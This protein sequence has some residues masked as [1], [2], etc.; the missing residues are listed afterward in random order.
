M[1]L[2]DGSLQ[3]VTL[4]RGYAWMYTGTIESL[5]KAAKF[6]R[7]IESSAGQKISAVEEIAYTNGWIDR[8]KLHP[9]LS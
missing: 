7:T 6:V 8:D 4:G 9:A 3:V 5:Y 1:R 2:E